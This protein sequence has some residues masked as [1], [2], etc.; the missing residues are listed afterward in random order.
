VRTVQNVMQK[1]SADH[2]PGSQKAQGLEPALP[3]GQGERNF[4]I[5]FDTL[6][7]FRLLFQH[8]HHMCAA[9]EFIAVYIGVAA[10]LLYAGFGS[11]DGLF[12]I[13]PLQSAGRTGLD[14]GRSQIVG[15]SC[16]AHIAF[17]NFLCLFIVLGHFKGTG[18]NTFLAPDA[19]FPVHTHRTEFFIIVKSPAGTYRHAGGIGTMHAGF[20]PE[21]PS[22]IAFW[23]DIILKVNNHIRIV[24]QRRRILIRARMFRLSGL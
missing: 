23:C 24:L 10:Q 2:A 1:R 19:F 14:A 7:N 4:R 17:K 22:D 3:Y 11:F 6:V 20:L 15:N 5:L 9:Y 13:Q 18:G 21:N 16:F 12:L 8:I